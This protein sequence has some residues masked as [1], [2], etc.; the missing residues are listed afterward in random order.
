MNAKTGGG[1]P[2]PLLYVHGGGAVL[3]PDRPAVHWRNCLTPRTQS[4]L[5]AGANA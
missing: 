1:A 3:F 5:A 4:G 2:K